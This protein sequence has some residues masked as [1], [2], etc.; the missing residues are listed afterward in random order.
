LSP[1]RKSGVTF[2]NYFARKAVTN[3]NA[4]LGLISCKMLDE[5]EYKYHWQKRD[6]DLNCEYVEFNP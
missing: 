2:W 3:P 1:T 6:P 5:R 4:D